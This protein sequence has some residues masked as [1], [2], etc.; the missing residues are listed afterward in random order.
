MR[1]VCLPACPQ[2][3]SLLGL[4]E[5]G[6]KKVD[7][8]CYQ[9]QSKH[10]EKERREEERGDNDKSFL[11]PLDHLLRARP[12]LEIDAYFVQS[13][14]WP[15]GGG[16]EGSTGARSNRLPHFNTSPLNSLTCLLLLLPG[17]PHPIQ[18]GR[19]AKQTSVTTHERS[20]HADFMT[21]RRLELERLQ[22]DRRERASS[23]NCACTKRAN[24]EKINF[25][26]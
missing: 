12:A 2:S 19:P 26:V 20:F 23:R 16:M 3:S 5:R 18:P 9:H 22:R 15:G 6:P 11:A 24:E 1:T 25:P 4:G 10:G 7:R 13:F 14:I 8:A 21:S 17:P